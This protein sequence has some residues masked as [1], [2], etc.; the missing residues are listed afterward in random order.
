MGTVRGVDRRCLRGG[1]C[2]SLEVVE[3]QGED[4][5]DVRGGG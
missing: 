5:E 2:M 3:M 4:E 1:R